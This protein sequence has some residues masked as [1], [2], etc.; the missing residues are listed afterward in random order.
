MTKTYSRKPRSVRAVQWVGYN[1]DEV[2][3][4]VPTFHERTYYGGGP[5]TTGEYIDP[6][7]LASIQVETNEWLVV[8]EDGEINHMIDLHFHREFAESDSQPGLT[9]A[10]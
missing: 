9:T 1:L 2:Q 5:W 10:P 7:G 3:E 8:G 4:L 6:W